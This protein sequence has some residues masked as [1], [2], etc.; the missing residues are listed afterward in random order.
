MKPL[1]SQVVNLTSEVKYAAI[2]ARVSTEDQGKGF[3]IPIQWSRDR[4]AGS[5]FRCAEPWRNM[6]APRFWSA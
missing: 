4:R 2:Y 6:N 3:S 1:P 5:S